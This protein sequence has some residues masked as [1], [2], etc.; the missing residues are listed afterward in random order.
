MDMM[1]TLL[2]LALKHKGKHCKAVIHERKCY[3]EFIKPSAR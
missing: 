2:I 3:A 1:P